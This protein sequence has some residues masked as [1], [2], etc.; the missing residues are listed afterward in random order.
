MSTSSSL[1]GLCL[2]GLVGHVVLGGDLIGRI[3]RTV[4]FVRLLVWLL[5]RGGRPHCV[6]RGVHL[7]RLDGRMDVHSF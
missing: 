5:T 2:R 1:S 4:V 3:N 6:V 7:D